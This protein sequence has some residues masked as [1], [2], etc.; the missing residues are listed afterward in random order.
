MRSPSPNSEFVTRDSVTG[1]LRAERD[2]ISAESREA[3]AQ[4][5]A[6]AAVAR[7]DIEAARERL[8]AAAAYNE[9]LRR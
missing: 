8:L 5:W 1:S 6:T 3:L 7:L 4:F 2:R 9:S